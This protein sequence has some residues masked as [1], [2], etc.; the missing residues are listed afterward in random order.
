VKK[1]FLYVAAFVTGERSGGTCMRD[2][3]FEH[4]KQI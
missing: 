3:A 4:K 2:S 1:E